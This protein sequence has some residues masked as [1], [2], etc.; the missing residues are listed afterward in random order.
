MEAAS[1][2]SM[3]FVIAGTY[4]NL[5]KISTVYDHCHDETGYVN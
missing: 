2:D 3:R 1:R 5:P 4:L